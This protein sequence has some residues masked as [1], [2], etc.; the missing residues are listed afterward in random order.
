MKLILGPV[1]VGRVGSHLIIH[2][3]GFGL[4][5][6]GVGLAALAGGR[7]GVGPFDSPPAADKARF[8]PFGKLRAGE[9][10]AGRVN[11]STELRVNG[12]GMRP[13]GSVA[14]R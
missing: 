5:R 3:F 4:L 1:G 8:D 10:T 7:L 2:Q 6:N 13:R 14:L 11:P 9:L 12:R